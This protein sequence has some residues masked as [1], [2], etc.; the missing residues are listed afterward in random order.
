MRSPPREAEGLLRGYA[1]RGN[2]KFNLSPA[3]RDGRISEVMKCRITGGLF[4][5][6][7]LF[8]SAVLPLNAQST[9]RVLHSFTGGD[10][11]RRPY[12]G[13]ILSG[14]TL[15]GTSFYGGG[16]DAGM[17]FAVNTDG[18]GFTNLHSFSIGNDGF[19]P[20]GGLVLSGNTLYGTT[21]WGGTAD[22]GTVYAMNT[23]GSG[24]TTLHS[25]TAFTDPTRPFGTNQDGANPFATLILS[26]NTLYG[27]AEYGGT[28][29]EGTVFAVNTD[30]SGFTNV[31]S[32]TSLTHNSKT[33]TYVNQDGVVPFGGVI[34]SDHRL[35]GTATG[36]GSTGSGTVFAVNTDG[37]GFVN[38]HNFT[39]LTP[40]PPTSGVNSDGAHPNRSL[41]L[42]GDT[43]YGTAPQGGSSGRGTIFAINTETLEFTTLYSF[44]AG[45]GS[46]GTNSDGGNPCDGLILSGSTLYGTASV[47]GSSGYGTVFAVQ[48]NGTGFATLYNFTNGTDGAWPYSGLVLSGNTLFGAASSA[49][50]SGVGTVFAL[51][52]MPP[53]GIATASN[54]IVLSW[55]IWAPNCSLQTSTNLSSGN[56]SNVADGI[57]IVGTNYVFT[58]TMNGHAAF[59]RLQSQ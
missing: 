4:S 26:G 11:G 52:L 12:A 51:T 53:L 32:F 17:V 56:W 5:A 7:L 14:N 21:D 3:C 22:N 31:Y 43:L 42:S 44:T 30:G 1:A 9:F 20:H 2:E 25:F 24:F 55:P 6:A 34:F 15:Y 16:S 38:L 35:Y 47:G 29:A 50:N 40:L 49:N 36:G 41:I 28:S 54:Q 48:T 58:K 23:D 46:H 18:S 33:G 19:N 37:S 59:F 45:S 8:L 27:T 10:N 39:A 13:L 57:T